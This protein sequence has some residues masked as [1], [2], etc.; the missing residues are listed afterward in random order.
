MKFILNVTQVWAFGAIKLS[1]IFF[2]RRIFRGKGFEICSKAMMAIIIAWTL[3]FF[4]S[5]LF[6][7]G[8]NFEA[9]W[10]TLE[11]LLTECHPQHT[12]QQ[13]MAVS[14][15]LTDALI[16]AIPIPLVR[17]VNHWT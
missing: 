14:D 1:V 9:N 17:A 3:S 6:G 16:L 10:S 2:Y 8:T 13:A 5:F 15:V 12:Y 11:A 7:C 4:F